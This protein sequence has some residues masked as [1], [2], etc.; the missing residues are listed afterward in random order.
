MKGRINPSNFYRTTLTGS[1]VNNSSETGTFEV[2]DKTVNGYTL[3][4]GSYIFWLIF[5]ID[6]MT[7]YEIFRCTN[8]SSTTITYDLRISPNSKQTHASGTL[9]SMNDFAEVIRYLGAQ[10]DDFG[11]VEAVP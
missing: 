4:D 1:S 9:V 5:A 10:V 6:D 7:K 11:Y 3:E 2:T 8:V